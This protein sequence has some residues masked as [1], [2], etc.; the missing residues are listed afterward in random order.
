MGIR[1][2]RP[3]DDSEVSHLG[4]KEIDHTNTKCCT[5]GSHETYIMP[6][7]KSHWLVCS[8]GKDNCT[9]YLCSR[10]WN[11]IQNNLP[12][13]Y[14]NIIKSMR[15]SRTGHLS[16]FIG[17][18]KIVI[19]QW[20][21]AKTLGLRDLNIDNDNFNVPIDLSSNDIYRK[22]DVKFSSKLDE[23]GR[24]H[25]GIGKYYFDILIILIMNELW[26]NIDRV[27]IIPKDK[28]NVTHIAIYKDLSISDRY[29]IYSVDS[30]PFNDTY[31]S[32]DIPEFFNPWD[33]WK[34]RYNKKR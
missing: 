4:G 15:L 30:T 23:L 6:N 22:P 16:K 3:I 29:E 7:G 33:L 9:K 1:M 32:V 12:N 13:S 5:C 20:I 26:N 21:V 10:C 25:I 8:C 27:Y 31:H 34:G 17:H 19:S 2:L 28:I 24:W 11:K 18:G 14:K